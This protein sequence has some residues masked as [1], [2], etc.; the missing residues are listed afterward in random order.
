MKLKRA[1]AAVSG[2]AF[3]VLLAA[4]VTGCGGSTGPYGGGG[5]DATHTFLSTTVNA[6]YHTLTINKTDVQT[7]PAAGLSL[8]TSSASGHTHSFTL[9]QVQLT[10][11]NGGTAVIQSTAT[12]DVTGT[13]S[14]DFTI[15]KWF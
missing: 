6:H 3:L 12:S 13:H 8:T 15:S 2:A 11:V 10:T 7:P 14:H 9:T 1:V 5:G 4:G